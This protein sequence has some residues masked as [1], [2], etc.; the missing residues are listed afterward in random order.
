MLSASFKYLPN[1]P[2]MKKRTLV[3]LYF[4]IFFG[5]AFS[6]APQ[7]FNY[8]AIARDNSGNPIPNASI[9][10]KLALTADSLGSSV[11]WE[12]LFNPVIT[13][14]YGLFTVVIG[15]GTRQVSSTVA[16]FANINW[17]VSPI[18]LKT[19]VYYL[20]A[21]KNMGSSRLW[22]VPYALTA[23]DINGNLSKLKVVGS[24]VSMDSA[25]FEVKNSTG[26]T[27]FA[28]YPEGVRIY[29]DDG[30][31]KGTMKGGFAIGGFGTSKSSSQPLFIVDR[32]SIRAYIDTSKTKSFKGGFAIG[33]F[34]TSKG[35]TPN[36]MEMTPKNY[37]IGEGSGS[38]NTSGRYNSFVGYQ[39]GL[40]NTTGWNNALFGYQAGL[41]NTTGASNL[42]VGYQ[43]GFSNTSGNFN[44]F[45]GYQSGYDN[46]TG[47]QNTF[48]GSFS[49]A[50]NSN[51]GNN[52]FLGYNSGFSNIS[53][54]ENN[55]IGENAGYSNTIGSYNLYVGPMA[56]YSSVAGDSNL[57]IGVKS[58]YSFTGSG[59]ANIFI[60]SHAGAASV[61]GSNNIYIGVRAAPQVN[62]ASDNIYIGWRAGLLGTYNP[63]FIPG[64][65]NI[66][67]GKNAG[68]N[69]SFLWGDQFGLSYPL[70][71]LE[72]TLAIDQND[73]SYYAYGYP[74]Q[75]YPAGDM[76]RYPLIFGNFTTET[77]RR[78][79]TINGIYGYTYMFF[80]NGAAGGKTAWFSVSDGRMKK[81]IIPI[82]NALEKIVELRGVSYNWADTL[83]SEKGRQIGF[84]AQ[85]AEKVIP[86]VVRNAGGTYS[87]TYGPITALLVEG[88]KEQQK[89]IVAQRSE[90]EAQKKEIQSLQSRMDQIEA[91]LA[92]SGIKK[93]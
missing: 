2:I 42:F 31:A 9:Q 73:G 13:N 26:Q 34:G 86:E 40:N 51:G 90:L 28:V 6:Q 8:Q 35:F 64:N 21:W 48:L 17:S 55:F 5:I 1:L 53:G 7:G 44:S 78:G 49:G 30:I 25:L 63:S 75:H 69:I 81:N 91:T 50:N 83:N 45:M 18:F 77:G 93:P 56:G 67:I 36:F 46:T 61:S 16:T 68:C 10:V 57:F 58:G 84:I 19:Q 82:A 12:E 66:W 38:N 54:N 89:I 41:S 11:Y 27:V 85:E 60:G 72:N 71:P 87:M 76:N 20:G 62:S 39:T 70:R 59:K 22:S 4:L 92:K 52:T 88:I 32:D 14:A 15:R 23:D 74:N 79:V 29:V 24:A 33:G 80:V 65:G 3:F 37:F 43:S 47:L